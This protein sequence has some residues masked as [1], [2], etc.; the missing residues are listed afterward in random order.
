MI[1]HQGGCH[2]GKVRFTTGYDPML[3]NQCNCNRCRKLFGTVNVF[4]VFATDDVEI[5]GS[6]NVYDFMGGSGMPMHL[7]F[8]SKCATITHGFAD[9][10]EGFILLPIGVFDDSR[11]FKP[12]MEIFRNHGLDWLTNDGS[13]QESFG[14][15]AVMERLMA[16]MENLDQRG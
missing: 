7:H 10:I 11:Q 2:C 12:K 5:E 15:A 9:A 8:C 14:E 4:T 6:T 16:L 3:V 13:I 1:K